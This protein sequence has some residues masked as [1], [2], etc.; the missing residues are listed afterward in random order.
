MVYELRIYHCVPGCLPKVLDRFENVVFDFW[1]KYGIKQ[2]GFWTT[3]IGESNQDITY[4]LQW[5]SLADREAKW[6]AFQSDPEWIKKR[7]AT[8][9]NGPLVL[10][11]SNSILGTT[12][13]SNIK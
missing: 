3:L 6:A 12:A 11:Y 9:P 4:M 1:N 13:F 10:S 8:E 7:A 5:D 2:V